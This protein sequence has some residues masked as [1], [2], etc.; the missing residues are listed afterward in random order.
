MRA[1]ACAIGLLVLGLGC[2][3]Q[4][5]APKSPEP[6]TQRQRDS[7]LGASALPGARGVQK[8]LAIAD[9]AAARRAREDS[10]AQQP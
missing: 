6:L 5:D 1:V 10:V 3:G 2:G 7:L 9:S 8:A 4:K